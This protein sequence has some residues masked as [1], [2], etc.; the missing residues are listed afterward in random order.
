MTTLKKVEL[1]DGQW[2]YVQIDEAVSFAEMETAV[3]DASGFESKGMREQADQAASTVSG[4]I[5]AMSETAANALKHSALG[6]VN[7]VTLE[8]GITLGG[9]AGIPFVTSGKADGSVN[10][11][12]EFAPKDNEPD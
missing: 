2:V 6:S 11:T 1:D 7:K 3:E 5:R 4:L 12:I 9:E 8:F 10:V